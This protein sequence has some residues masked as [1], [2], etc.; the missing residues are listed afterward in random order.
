MLRTN[1]IPTMQTN[2][3]RHH[4]AVAMSVALL[5]PVL[6]FALGAAT[7]AALLAP[8]PATLQHPVALDPAV[9]KFRQDT[10][11]RLVA[12]LAG[13]SPRPARPAACVKS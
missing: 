4:P 6:A 11:L 7:V 8:P 3:A 1:K 10:L 5:G 13:A 12:R 2:L 9:R